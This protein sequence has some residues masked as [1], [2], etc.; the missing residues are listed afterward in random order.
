GRA[1][2]RLPAGELPFARLEQ[3]G[4]FLHLDEARAVLLASQRARPEAVHLGLARGER[5][6][7]VVEL[8]RTHC[9]LLLGLAAAACRVAETLLAGTKALGLGAQP[10]LLARDARLRLRERTLRGRRPAL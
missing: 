10:R 1:Q 4:P 8:A 6:L 5:Q 2:L 3:G 7:A 9:E